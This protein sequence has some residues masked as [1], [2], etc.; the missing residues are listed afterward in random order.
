[1]NNL[2]LSIFLLLE[3]DDDATFQEW[4]FDDFEFVRKLGSGGVASVICAKEKQSHYEVAL[5]IQ[6]DEGDTFCEYDLHESMDHPNIVKM[7]DYFFS[8]K[9]LG[10]KDLDN[11]INEEDPVDKKIV[12]IMELCADGSLFD[13]IRDAPDGYLDESQAATFLW[14]AINAIEHVHNKGIIH[15]DI[16]SLNF[17]VSDGKLKLCDFGM[18]VRKEEREIVGGSPMYMSWE[19]LKAWKFMTDDFDERVDIYS[20]GI[21]LYEMVLGYLPYEVIQDDNNEDFDSLLDGFDKLGLDDS[22]ED[23][24]KSP[25]LDIR[26][27]ENDTEGEPIYIPPPIF[28]DFISAECQDLMQ[29][30]AEP[31]V[32]DRITISE[33]KKHP[34]IMH[35]V[36]AAASHGNSS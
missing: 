7:I 31:I 16:K 27:L 33:I 29:R 3:D 11:E 35:H 26:N 24:F 17:L 21:I 28:P 19:H 36:P 34:W 25:V 22:I 1:M 9:S 20:L 30:M 15:C 32:D 4:S 23:Q 10:P 12:M 2:L 5:K 18:S 8:E 6:S 14:D 13:V